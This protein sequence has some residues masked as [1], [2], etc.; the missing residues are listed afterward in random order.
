[1]TEKLEERIKNLEERI[2]KLE[3][4]VSELDQ[5]TFG[6]RVFGGAHM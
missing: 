2:K 3:K 4:K 5:R 6:S 1:L